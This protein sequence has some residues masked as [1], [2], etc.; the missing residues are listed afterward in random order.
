MYLWEQMQ[1]SAST[2]AQQRVC[3]QQVDEAHVWRG[4]ARMVPSSLTMPT[5]TLFADP[6]MP[7]TSICLQATE[8]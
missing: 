1:E 5:P 3:M 7:R 6:S 8:L 2:I 4:L